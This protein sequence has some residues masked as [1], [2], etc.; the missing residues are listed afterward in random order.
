MEY[1]GYYKG[2]VKMNVKKYMLKNPHCMLGKTVA[3][4]GSTGGLGV[5]LCKY[6]VALGADLILIDRNRTLSLSLR[7][8]LLKICPD[9]N[10][11]CITA[12]LENL[13]SI[14][15]ACD[16]LEKLDVDFFLHNAG[17][18]KI[19]R[20]K[21]DTGFDNIFEINFVSPYYIINRILPRLKERDGKVLAVSSI[22]LSYSKTDKNDID[23]S[24]RHAC[25]LVYGNAKRFLTY[26][27]YGLL[28][29]NDVKF[30]IVHPGITLTKI[31]AHY[32]KWLFAIIK[33]PMK[34]IFMSPKK[35]ALSLLAGFFDQTR[36]GEWIGPRF[37]NVWGLPSKKSL[38]ACDE[39]E[40]QFIYKTAQDIYT[41]ITETEN[42]KKP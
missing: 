37:F 40:A 39:G 36:Q 13:K 27:L 19:D 30:S 7:E 42:T 14:S 8:Q 2:A 33:Y 28:N 4:T 21:C 25:S 15:L 32:P 16:E 12:D 41:R 1:N 11:V 22:A 23:F 9:A 10:I 24:T 38:N 18:Y 20:R 3:I 35:A 17:A 6:L 31:T 29:D 5:E 26:S 34:I